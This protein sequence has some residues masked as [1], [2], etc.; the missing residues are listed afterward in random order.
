MSPITRRPREVAHREYDEAI[1]RRHDARERIIPCCC[2]SEYTEEPPRV[3]NGVHD[4][5]SGGV[6]SQMRDAD[7]QVVHVEAEEQEEHGDV[8]LERAEEEQ[9]R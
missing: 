8:C 7:Q 9:C 3:S 5:V 4:P 1:I 6:G 2:C